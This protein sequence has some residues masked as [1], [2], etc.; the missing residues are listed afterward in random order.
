[1][2]GRLRPVGP[3]AAKV[4][5][6]PRV[7][8]RLELAREVR[9]KLSNLELVSRPRPILSLCVRGGVGA[10]VFDRRT[11]GLEIAASLRHDHAEG[12]VTLEANREPGTGQLPV[13]CEGGK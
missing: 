6:L 3:G 10:E 12:L 1:M 8:V 5:L 7:S 11:E 4:I 13:R 9:E 2:L